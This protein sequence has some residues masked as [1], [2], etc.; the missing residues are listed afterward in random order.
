MDITIIFK[1]RIILRYEV[2]VRNEVQMHRSYKI[3]VPY[4]CR[5]RLYV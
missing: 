3:S 1:V 5:G 2:Q 4:V